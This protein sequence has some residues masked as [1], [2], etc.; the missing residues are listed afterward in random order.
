MRDVPTTANAATTTLDPKGAAISAPIFH[1]T[2]FTASQV[3]EVQVDGVT[4]Q[5]GVGYFA[6]LDPA[7]QSLWVTLNGTVSAPVSLQVR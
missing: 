1:F 7:T 5:A 6:T 4:L 3:G 2:N